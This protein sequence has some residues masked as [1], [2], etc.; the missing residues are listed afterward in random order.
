MRGYFRPAGIRAKLCG[1]HHARLGGVFIPDNC[2]PWRIR[3]EPQPVPLIPRC[4]FAHR[5]ASLYASPRVAGRAGARLLARR[6]RLQSRLASVSSRGIPA[7]R[8]VLDLQ[9]SL[10]VRHIANQFVH[11]HLT[12]Q[13]LTP[14]SWADRSE[15]QVVRRGGRCLP[16]RGFYR[17]LNFRLVYDH[18]LAIEA[19]T[20]R[21][22]QNQKPHS[23]HVND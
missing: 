21:L 4:A 9:M 11:A 3:L 13:A 10:E 1:T 18:C 2:E 14:H 23:V 16:R 22:P 17:R 15:H 5:R 8:G 7:P 20:A 6:C 19:E 12:G